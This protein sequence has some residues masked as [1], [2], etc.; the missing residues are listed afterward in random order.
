M[1]KKETIIFGAVLLVAAGFFFYLYADFSRKP[2]IHIFHT[3]RPNLRRR[4]G[5]E[6]EPPNLNFAFDRDYKLTCVKVIPVAELAT[7]KYPHPLWELDS[8]SNSPPIRTFSYGMHIRGM[9]PSV[10]GA[11]P[12]PLQPN[13]TYRLEIE[14]GG[15]KGEHDFSIT[16]AASE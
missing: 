9:H 15:L 6:P 10:K 16:E 11:A 3:F 1:K 2:G 5:N 4:P 8:D 13:T 12:D 7:N 14:A